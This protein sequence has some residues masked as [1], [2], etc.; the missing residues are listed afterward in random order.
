MTILVTGGA[1]FIGCDFGVSVT[2]ASRSLASPE[3]VPNS[4][5]KAST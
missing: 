4:I 3:V 1:G 5:I 2:C